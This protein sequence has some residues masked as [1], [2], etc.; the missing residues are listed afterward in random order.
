VLCDCNISL[1]VFAAR[2]LHSSAYDWLTAVFAD[3]YTPRIE[4]NSHRIIFVM[5]SYMVSHLSQDYEPL[6]RY[7]QKTE[8]NGGSWWRHQRLTAAL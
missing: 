4:E 8:V 7:V 5:N 2:H 1:T 3:A 6:W